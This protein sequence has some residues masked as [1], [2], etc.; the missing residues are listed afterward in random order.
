MSAAAAVIVG[1]ELDR[2]L[3]GRDA[4]L[5]MTAYSFVHGAV[6]RSCDRRHS[7]S[8]VPELQLP[9]NA[10]LNP[11]DLGRR[12]IDA[13]ERD[14]VETNRRGVPLAVPQ[15]QSSASPERFA[16]V[17]SVRCSRSR[18]VT[19]ATAARADLDDHEV[20]AVLAHEVDLAERGSENRAQR[21]A[22]R[23]PRGTRQ[24][25]PPRGGRA[26]AAFSVVPE[27][28]ARQTRRRGPAAQSMRGRLAVAKLRERQRSMDAALVVE[29]QISR[30]VRAR[31]RRGRR[32]RTASRSGCRR[33]CPCRTASRDCS[34][35]RPERPA[36]R[37][38]R[39]SRVVVGRE[40]R[41]RIGEDHAVQVG[42][43]PRVGRV[44][45]VGRRVRRN[46]ARGVESQLRHEQS[47]RAR[48][49]R[50]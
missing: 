49:G 30:H 19:R 10:L 24:R 28:S 18:E 21:H 9:S 27:R 43:A 16:D 17:C 15:Q 8:N 13:V 32:R 33:R 48:V 7:A 12:P 38:D 6:G 20:A 42:A 14:D 31:A 4:L 45:D 39:S 36:T 11:A 2:G 50:R 25:A 40:Q 41:R 37:G 3:F 26:R 1:R 23:G 34:A 47:S 44:E 35:L 22:A 46:V 5:E 29:R